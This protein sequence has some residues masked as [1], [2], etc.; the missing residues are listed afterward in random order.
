MYNKRRIVTVANLQ[1]GSPIQVAYPMSDHEK[2]FSVSADF[3][4]SGKY[5]VF[6]AT[7]IAKTDDKLTIQFLFGAVNVRREIPNNFDSAFMPYYE[8]IGINPN[9]GVPF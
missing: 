2:G 6:N 5:Q 9:D 4:K 1:V 8:T 3:I 7:V